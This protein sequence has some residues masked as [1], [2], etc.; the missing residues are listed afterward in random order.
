MYLA[1][2]ENSSSERAEKQRQSK[3][4][5]ASAVKNLRNSGSEKILKSEVIYI[6]SITDKMHAMRLKRKGTDA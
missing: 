1:E 5:E 6:K 3:I 4:C 2:A